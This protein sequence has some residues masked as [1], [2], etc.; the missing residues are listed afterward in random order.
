LLFAHCSLLFG[1]GITADYT[2]LQGPGDST[3]LAKSVSRY[4][5]AAP[6]EA[7]AIVSVKVF[8]AVIASTIFDCNSSLSNAPML[9]YI[10]KPVAV[11]L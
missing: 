11:V 9:R 3:A 5:C 10:V 7:F 2:S 4:Q 1:Y 8:I 6:G